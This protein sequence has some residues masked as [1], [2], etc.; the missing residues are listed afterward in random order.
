MEWFLIAPTAGLAS[1]VLAAYL[2]YYVSRQDS[3]TEK[4]VEIS[5]AIREGA[6]AYLKRQNI[7]LAFFVLFMAIVLGGLFS[8]YEEPLHGVG[9][10]TAY[11]LGSFCTSLAAYLGMMAAVK[12]NVRTANAARAGLKKAFPIAFYGGAVMG[13]HSRF[14]PARGKP[15][16]LLIPRRLRMA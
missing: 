1:I 8:F 14:S 13:I 4:M 6:V 10:A 2:Y 12:A 15:P 5:D 16:L 11:V 3:G 9:I 7:T